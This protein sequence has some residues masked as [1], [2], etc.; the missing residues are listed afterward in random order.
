[1][2]CSALLH[3]CILSWVSVLA[4]VTHD[5]ESCW[6][7]ASNDLAQHTNSPYR[8]TLGIP[9]LGAGHVR[10]GCSDHHPSLSSSCN[11]GNIEFAATAVLFVV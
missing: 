5:S 7:D 3:D 9:R 2:F 8:T 11:T 6:V 10:G 4:K 1:M